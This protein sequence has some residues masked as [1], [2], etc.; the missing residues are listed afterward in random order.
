MKSLV[1]RFKE[2][3]DEIDC[4]LYIKRSVN[5]EPL[6]DNKPLRLFKIN[7]RS[8]PVGLD[9]TVAYGLTRNEAELLTKSFYK[10]KK[11]PENVIIYYDIIPD[12]GRVYSVFDNTEIPVMEGTNETSL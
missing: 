3:C 11:I 7:K 12:D 6:I 2:L 10:T 1:S 5:P 9:Q 8:L 4:Q